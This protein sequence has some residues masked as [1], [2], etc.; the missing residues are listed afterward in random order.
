MYEQDAYES[1]M[2]YDRDPA[3]AAVDRLHALGYGSDDIS[4]MMD[5]KTRERAF[6]SMVKA[7]GSEGMAAG[8]TTGGILGAIIA[9]LTA[10]GSVVAVAGTGGL[11]APLVAGPLAAALAGLGVGAAGGGIVGGLIGV[12]IAEKKAKDYEKGLREGGVLVAVKP[13][14]RESRDDVRRAL[15]DDATTT[16]GEVDTSV[17]YAGETRE[18]L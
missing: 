13:K 12:G 17:D 4:V 5:D 3:A 1:E 7:Q 6:S 2:Y 18:R 11:A 14:T 10:T 8:A 15:R 9:G 16:H